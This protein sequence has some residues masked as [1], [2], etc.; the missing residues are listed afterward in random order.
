M[1]NG[2]MSIAINWGQLGLNPEI[3]ILA[4]SSHGRLSMITN[5]A[6]RSEFIAHIH[7]HASVKRLCSKT[8]STK[9]RC[10]KIG[11]MS[12]WYYLLLPID[13]CLTTCLPVTDVSKEKMYLC[14]KGV[15]YEDAPHV[16]PT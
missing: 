2:C 14:R 1:A 5:A 10:I 4:T 16:V 6:T 3:Q 11:A 15:S 9:E 7:T 8:T 12:M 13:C